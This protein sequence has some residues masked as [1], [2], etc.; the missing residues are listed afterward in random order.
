MYHAKIMV[1]NDGPKN[2][3]GDSSMLY[4]GSHNLSPSAWGNQE[5]GDTQLSIA[6]WELG[7]VFPPGVGTS[8]VKNEI[9]KCMTLNLLC[10]KKYD[11]PIDEP[12][13]LDKQ[14]QF[15]NAHIK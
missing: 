1:V 12:F 9:M 11:I 2:E 3:V 6:N 15:R 7:V 13:I 8:K 4:F 5:K 14:I 10:P